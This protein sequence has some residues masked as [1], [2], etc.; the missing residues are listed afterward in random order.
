MKELF[1]TKTHVRWM[2]E[3]ELVEHRA[4]VYVPTLY[5][6]AVLLSF[7]LPL[8]ASRKKVGEA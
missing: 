1:V 7:V 6:W 5:G 3:S 8:V 4:T 2:A